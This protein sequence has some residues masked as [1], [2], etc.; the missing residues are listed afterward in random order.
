VKINSVLEYG[1]MPCVVKT[2]EQLTG[3]TIPFAGTV[4]FL[5]VAGLSEAVGGVEVC[6]AEPI[7]DEHTDLYLPAGI[8]SLRG[9]DALQF[10]RTRYGVGDGS[11]LGRISNQQVFL[12]SLART[13]QSSG[14]LGDPVK[15]YSIAKAALSNMELSS[16]LVDPAR[17]IS[18]AKALKDTDLAKIAFIQYPTGYTDDRSAVVPSESALLVNAALQNDV[19][20]I[21][22]PASDETDFA[23]AGD[24][25][26]PVAEVPAE[27]PAT[28]DPAAPAPTVEALPSDVTGQTAAETR[29]SAGRTLDDQ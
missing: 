6:V 19:P 22:D 13:M 23:S 16:S 15:L 21:F 11:D 7:E 18:I 10:L 20:V 27:E 3:L 4:Q 17:M 29:C 24:P 8:H 1:G 25:N 2:V 12:S 14:T 26:A 28:D 9:M 5:G